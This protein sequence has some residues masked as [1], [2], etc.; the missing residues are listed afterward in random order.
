[1]DSTSLNVSNLIQRFDT[2]FVEG[3]Q[4]FAVSFE[5]EVENN[6]LG[7]SRQVENTL[8]T[9]ITS[10]MSGT[11]A[12]PHH[13]FGGARPLA[14]QTNKQPFDSLKT[15]SGIS[16]TSVTRRLASRTRSAPG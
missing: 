12:S 3:S 4:Q 14:S 9:P 1:L 6:R 7:T 2:C 8:V 16:Q 13:S 5:F 10:L 15:K 11:A